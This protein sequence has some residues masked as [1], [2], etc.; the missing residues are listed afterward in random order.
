MSQVLQ[1]CLALGL[2]CCSLGLLLSTTTVMILL[3][4]GLLLTVIGHA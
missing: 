4:K 3:L 1:Y 2:I